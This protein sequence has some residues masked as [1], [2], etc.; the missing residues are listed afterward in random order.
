MHIFLNYESDQ[1]IETFEKTIQ[2]LIMTLKLYLL[3]FLNLHTT[4]YAMDALMGV[5][6]DKGRKLDD[7]E[8]INILIICLNATLHTIDA[9][10]SVVD[11]KDRKLD[12]DEFINIHIMYLN[13]GDES[14]E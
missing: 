4:L 3:T 9:L 13:T 2:F 5:V 7:E 14:F 8:F 11:N 1:V 6:D 10:I 12:D